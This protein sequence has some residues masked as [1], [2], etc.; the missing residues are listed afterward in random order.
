MGELLYKELCYKVVGCAYSV[1]N[2]L[3]FGLKEKVYGNAF[4]VLLK[5]KSVSYSRELYSPI[6]FKDKVIA[7]NFLDFLIDDC[8]VVELKVGSNDF[9]EVCNQ[10]FSYLRAKDLKLGLIIRFTREG[11]R[12][13]RIPNLY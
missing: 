11:V 6:V 12:V 10:V 9:K 1:Y 7:K 8:L 2:E 3:G 13:K 4:E 5:E